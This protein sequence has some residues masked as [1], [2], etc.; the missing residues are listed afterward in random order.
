MQLW[1]FSLSFFG[2]P[3]RELLL[4]N[5]FSTI[6]V[7]VAIKVLSLE[8]HMCIDHQ[9]NDDDDDNTFTQNAK[10]ALNDFDAGDL[11]SP[12][13]HYMYILVAITKKQL[14]FLCAII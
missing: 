3:C 7:I 5:L 2:I 10:C 8:N 4:F 1:S 11:L 12:L 13:S 9:D 14:S 6:V